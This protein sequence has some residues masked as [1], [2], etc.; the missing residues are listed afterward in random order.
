MS[1]SNSLVGKTPC[2]RGESATRS[3][4]CWTRRRVLGS[5]AGASLASL[6]RRI[7]R[8]GGRPPRTVSRTQFTEGLAAWPYGERFADGPGNV[9]LLAYRDI[10]PYRIQLIPE[11]PIALGDTRAHP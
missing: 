1:L 5:L 11:G 10:A 3:G 4:V 7:A 9:K 2:C 6:G 8:R